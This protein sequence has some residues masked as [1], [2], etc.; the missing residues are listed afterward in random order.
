MIEIENEAQPVGCYKRR[1]NLEIIL[2]PLELDLG[3]GLQC[4][5]NTG[6]HLLSSLMLP[7]WSETRAAIAKKIVA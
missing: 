4:S 2:D 5:C 3:N 6:E 1:N 7:H